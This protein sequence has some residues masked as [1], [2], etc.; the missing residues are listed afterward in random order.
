[1]TKP[2]TIKIQKLDPR[3]KMPEQAHDTD[4]GWDVFA[5]EVVSVPPGRIVRVET[6]IAMALPPGWECQVRPRSGMAMRGIT[7]VNSPGTIDAGYRGQVCVL[8]QNLT[9]MPWSSRVRGAKI[10]QLVFKRVPRVVLV[11][12]E[13]LDETD[14]GDGGFGSTGR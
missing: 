8:L 3:A 5:L 2:T 11:E 13:D 6:G 7:V 14:R 1:M 10:A 12:A 4:A 9:N